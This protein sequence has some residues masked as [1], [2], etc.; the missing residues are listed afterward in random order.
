[1]GGPPTLAQVMTRAH[2]R[3]RRLASASRLSVRIS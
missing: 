2:R 3:A 1:V